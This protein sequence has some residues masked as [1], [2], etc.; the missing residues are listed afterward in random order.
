VTKVDRGLAVLA[1]VAFVL[2]W[3]FAAIAA[4]GWAT[5]RSD[6][7]GFSMLVPPGVKFTEKGHGGGWGS[8]EATHGGIRFLAIGKLGEHATAEEIERYGV[9]IT[10]VAAAHW[11]QIDRGQNRN[12]W[13][14]FRTVEAVDGQKLIFGRYGT[15]AKG[16][17]LVLLQTTVR[18]YEEHKADYRKWYNSVTLL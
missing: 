16:S 4:D 3:S 13:T 1:L 11:K 9:R 5:Y 2:G 7:Y 14:W 12:G 6:E 8:L 18:D 17:Y 10:G 15:G